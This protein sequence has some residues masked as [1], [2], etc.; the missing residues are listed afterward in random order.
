MTDSL[1]AET[2][3]AARAANDVKSE[4]IEAA[5]A[6]APAKGWAPA[7]WRDKPGKQMPAYPDARALQTAT[8]KL[9]AMPPLVVASEALDL[10]G[11]LAE[12]AK[13][14]AFL[15]QGGDCAESFADFSAN[16]VRDSFRVLL[17][18]AAVLTYGAK[19]PVVKIGRIAGQF[20]KPRSSDNET[21]DGV[22]L[23]SYRGDIVNGF[24]F[25]EDAR[26]PDPARMIEA[27]TQSAAS[28]NLLRA[29]ASGGY[30][31]MHRVADW[32]LGFAEG[33]GT[34]R[35]QA[36]AGQIAA[37]LDFMEACGVTP[38]NTA[39]M[40][41]VNFFTSHEALLLEYEE[42]LTREDSITGLPLA[43]SGHMIWIGDR[44]R[45]PDGAHLEYCRGVLNPI[46]LKCGPSLEPDELLRLIDILN[47][48]DAAGRLVLICRF[49]AGKIGDHL[50]GLMRKVKEAGRTVVWSCDPMHGNTE[51]SESGFKTRKFDNVLAE[52]RDFFA[53]A[54]AEGVYPGGVH[55]EMTGQDVTECLGGVSGVLPEDL[56]K[57]YHTFCDPR[58]NASQALELAFLVAEELVATAPSHRKPVV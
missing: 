20:A 22:T 39:A 50:A 47:P 42:A 11:R 1:L 32:T 25:T 29:F 52:V 34:E 53:I 19:K 18:M 4:A 8:T 38:R 40:R 36:I 9:S 14:D 57:R 54:R 37:A 2:S 51:K 24:D 44:T 10:R 41:T 31:D 30:A 35:Y 23:P 3:A 16:M 17:Q 6:A 33:K 49:G 28:L 27:Y 45:Q 46:G 15:L 58:L 7:S 21:V 5:K 13:G 55:F 48:D 26:V 43:G 12:V 56:S